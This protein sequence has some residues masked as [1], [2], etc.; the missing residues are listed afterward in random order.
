MDNNVP[1]YELAVGARVVVYK[2]TGQIVPRGSTGV[3][4]RFRPTGSA[5]DD[6]VCVDFDNDG[7]GHW[8]HRSHLAIIAD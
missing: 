8:V 2:G 7:C 4:L 3:I 1:K 5:I 6:L